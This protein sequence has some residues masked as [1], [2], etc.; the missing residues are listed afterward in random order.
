MDSERKIRNPG[1]DS[2]KADPLESSN[3]L[4]GER[5]S[6]NYAPRGQ[7]GGIRVLMKYTASKPVN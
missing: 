5:I 7:H 3:L 1:I 2:N 6:E 4:P